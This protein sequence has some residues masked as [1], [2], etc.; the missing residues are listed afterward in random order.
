VG[1][2]GMVA[3]ISGGSSI[4]MPFK[5]ALWRT[6]AGGSATR[7]NASRTRH[8][9][10]GKW[11]RSGEITRQHG[12]TAAAAWRGNATSGALRAS[13]G[14][15]KRRQ[16]ISRGAARRVAAAARKRRQRRQRQHGG[17]AGGNIHHG[18]AALYMA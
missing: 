16:S 18:V 7:R 10:N 13:N 3:S 2:A 8:R 12:V 6:A 17:G 15:G 5:A 1:V 4:G 11:R 14:G 9:I